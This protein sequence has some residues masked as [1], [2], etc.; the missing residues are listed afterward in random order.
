[1][2]STVVYHGATDKPQPGK[3]GYLVYKVE[4]EKDS[5]VS[6]CRGCAAPFSMTRRRHHCRGCGRIYCAKCSSKTMLVK[7]WG[8]ETRVCDVCYDAPDVSR[9]RAS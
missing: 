8:R 2:A 5:D 7:T 3:P 1:M 4:W 9:A 6:A